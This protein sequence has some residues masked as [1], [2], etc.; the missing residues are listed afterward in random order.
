VLLHQAAQLDDEMR[1]HASGAHGY[2]RM[3]ANISAIVEFLPGALASFAQQHPDIHVQ[4]EEH[5]SSAIA[6]AVADNSADLGIVS[7]LPAIDG[8]STLPFRNDDLVVVLK[9]D[10]PLAGR[11]SISFADLVD[12]PFV[13][14]HAGSALHRLLMRA[15]AEADRTLN[16][17]VQVTSFDAAC[18]M[19]AAG[20]GV[21]I[22]PRA[23][24]TAYIRSL[25]L[26]SVTLAD[27]WAQRQ[28]FLCIRSGTPLHSAA[29]LL[30]DH[31]QSLASI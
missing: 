21:S 22:V 27:A 12:Q 4:L 28:L 7:E 31:L 23:A 16:L 5:I 29:K 14:L 6:T 3:F 24:T 26:A 13:G 30:Y 11:S 9:P 17:R 1:R 8:L 20:L 2:V 25:S 10:H 19:V 15:A 18:A